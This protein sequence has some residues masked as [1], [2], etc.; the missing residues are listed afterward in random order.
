MT[1]SCYR[2]NLIFGRPTLVWKHEKRLTRKGCLMEF[3]T[4]KILFSANS[5]S[6]SSLAMMS[7]F[8]KAL[9]AKYS[10]VFLYLKHIIESRI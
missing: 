7:P 3:A 1:I 5:D 2:D 6:T 9:M 4:S 10:P 8:F